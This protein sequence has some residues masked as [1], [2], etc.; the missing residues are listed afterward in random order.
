METLGP[1][2]RLGNIGGVKQ[3]TQK[4]TAGQ[5]HALAMANSREQQRRRTHVATKDV[6]RPTSPA[7]PPHSNSTPPRHNSPGVVSVVPGR[8]HTDFIQQVQERMVLD[9]IVIGSDIETRHKAKGA[10]LL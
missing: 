8:L 10:N 5:C 7:P 2:D 4:D 3:A 1:N 6:N 9:G